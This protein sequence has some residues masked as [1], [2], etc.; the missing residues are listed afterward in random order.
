MRRARPATGRSLLRGAATALADLHTRR[1]VE[2]KTPKGSSPATWN[3][4]G[5]QSERCRGKL[6]P[7]EKFNGSGL[8]IM[9]MESIL[10]KEEKDFLL[11]QGLQYSDVFDARG[12]RRSDAQGKM[13][14]LGKGFMLGSKCNAAG[15]RLR[16]RAGHCIQCDTSKIAYERRHRNKG[17]VYLAY[18]E[19]MSLVKIG[20]TTDV[21][22]RIYS[23]NYQSYGGA[24]DWVVV[25]CA[26]TA[27]MGLLERQ[28]QDRLS[29]YKVKGIYI[30]GGKSQSAAEIF[31]CELRIALMAF[32]E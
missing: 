17:T 6:C 25:D 7:T 10:T 9:T 27:E 2:P 12:M 5:L 26:N 23:L 24:N 16:T 22:R 11:D 20:S 8:L 29:K 28:I 31:R 3:N 15:H 19:S 30:K 13:R 14:D 18:S 1:T 32:R 21:E 4:L